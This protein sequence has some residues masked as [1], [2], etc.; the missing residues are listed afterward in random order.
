MVVFPQ[1]KRTTEFNA[2]KFNTLAIKIAKRASVPIIPVA[3]RTDAWG[4][5][6]SMVK[7]F[8]KIRPHCPVHFEF[9]EPM[10][11]EG[12]GR[13]CQERIVKF[14]DERYSKWIEEVPIPEEW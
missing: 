8:G 14:I 10:M 4:S 5:N 1:G 3:L 13:D 12:H 6:G 9:G 11:V 7:D 2:E